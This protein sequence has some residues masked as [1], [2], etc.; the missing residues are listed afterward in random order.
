[1]VVQ[2]AK[3]KASSLSCKNA[4]CFCLQKCIIVFE[5]NEFG[6][7]LRNEPLEKEY[8]HYDMTNSRGDVIALYNSQGDKVVTYEYDA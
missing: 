2:D 3:G 4:R 6:I 8:L 1:M 5:A 7:C